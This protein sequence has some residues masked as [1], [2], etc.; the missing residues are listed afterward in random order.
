MET[1]IEEK[2]NEEMTN[3]EKQIEEQK[4][5]KCFNASRLRYYKK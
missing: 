3:K 5:A 1:K 4:M 2:D